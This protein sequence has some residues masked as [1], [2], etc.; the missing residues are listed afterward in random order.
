[1]KLDAGVVEPLAI[2]QQADQY[3][4]HTDDEQQDLHQSIDVGAPPASACTG[5]LTTI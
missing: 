1:M 4:H 5:E 3:R 2:P